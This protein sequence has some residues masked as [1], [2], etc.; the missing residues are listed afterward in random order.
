MIILNNEEIKEHTS[1]Y[2]QDYL[3]RKPGYLESDY[4]TKA[5]PKIE[6]EAARQYPYTVK[7]PKAPKYLAKGDFEPEYEFVVD[8]P[9]KGLYS[10]IWF[11]NSAKGL[12]LR[13]GYVDGNSSKLCKQQ[14]AGTD[15]HMVLAGATGQGKSVTLNSIIYGFCLEYAPWE[16]QLVLCDAKIVEFKSYAVQTP[17]PHIKSI[18]ATD[19]ADYII[20]VLADLEREMSLWNNIYVDNDVKNI[21]DFRKKTGLCIPRHVIVID[22]FQTMLKK[23]G[24]KSNEIMRILYSFAKLGRNTGFHLLLASQEIGSDIPKDV[25]S[26][27]KIRAAVGCTSSVSELILN[28][29][30]AKNNYGKVGRLIIN[31]NIEGNPRANNVNVRVPYMPDDQRIAIGQDVISV[32]RQTPFKQV[33]S[34]YDATDLTPEDKYKEYLQHF[35]QTSNRVL[36]GEPSYVTDDPEQVVKLNFSTTLGETNIIVL[37]PSPANQERYFKMLRS[38]IELFSNTQNLVIN[39]DKMFQDKCDASSLAITGF[40]SEKRFFDND[41][42]NLSFTLVARRKL[43]LAIDSLVFSTPMQSDGND[44]A[45]YREFVKGSEQDTELNRQRFKAG[46]Y[47]LGNDAQLIKMFGLTNANKEERYKQ[48]LKQVAIAIDSIVTTYKCPDC[49][50]EVKHMPYIFTWILG[51]DRMMGLGRDSKVANIEKLKQF[52]QDCSDVNMGYFVFMSA[53]ED[54]K[55]LFNGVN[56]VIID[57]AQTRELTQI[58]AADDFPDTVSKQLGVLFTRVPAGDMPKCV[59][60]KKMR[61]QDEI[62]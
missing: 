4:L 16:V 29:D 39:L 59:K 23:A 36:L 24:K 60:F 8:K 46:M 41:V 52:M 3:S 31:N 20:S 28:N 11:G 2:L 42:L 25:L 56:W 48:S 19:D 12:T 22:E 44:D 26:N 49:M 38:N 58:K 62:L 53:V 17:M 32:C 47:L 43:C 18:A 37:T 9:F 14:F 33:L 21:S 30:A 1:L 51:A 57:G 61:L 27:I 15:V 6:A 7:I 45:F 34:F 40:Y 13:C 54:M 10:D 35:K 5:F 50:I 55:D